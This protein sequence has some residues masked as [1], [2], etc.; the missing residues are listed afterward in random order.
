MIAA[1]PAKRRSVSD[2]VAGS[3]FI[4][5][6]ARHYLHASGQLPS[7]LDWREPIG[8]QERLEG[9]SSHNGEFLR[10]VSFLLSGNRGYDSNRRRY[11]LCQWNGNLLAARGSVTC[12]LQTR[13]YINQ[14]NLQH[15][16]PMLI[17]SKMR[18]FVRLIGRP[19]FFLQKMY[20]SKSKS[21]HI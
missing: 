9:R 18:K 19:M 1:R 16:R 4:L 6:R 14:P 3:A 8:L 10:D 21:T 7:H 17:N 13:L 5:P 2:S 20:L 12:C 15:N 11:S